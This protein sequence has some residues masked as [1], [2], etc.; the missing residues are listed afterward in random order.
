MTSII[1]HECIMTCYEYIYNM[2]M[3]HAAFREVFQKG[4]AWHFQLSLF[5]IMNYYELLPW[6]IISSV[7]N[8]LYHHY[9]LLTEIKYHR[10]QNYQ[11]YKHYF[12]FIMNMNVLDNALRMCIVPYE[13]IIACYK[14]LYVSYHQ[15]SL[16][17]MYNGW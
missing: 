13:C 8:A 15:A 3:I 1:P 12:R 11:N 10:Y 17:I 2:L 5:C 6:C 4:D 9:A 7:H 14:L 16:C